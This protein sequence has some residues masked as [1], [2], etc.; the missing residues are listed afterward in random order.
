MNYDELEKNIMEINNIALKISNLT[1]VAR[2]GYVETIDPIKFEN[3]R[4]EV[5]VS[6]VENEIRNLISKLKDIVNNL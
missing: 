4:I 6:D 1:R 3:K 2:N 5:N